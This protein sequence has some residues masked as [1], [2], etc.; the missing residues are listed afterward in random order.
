MVRLGRRVVAKIF[1][2]LGIIPPIRFG[3][4]RRVTPV[5]RSFGLDRGGPI[6]RYYIE[7]F[8]RRHVNDIRGSV[9]EAGGLVNY[10]KEFGGK[11]VSRADVLYPKS[12]FPDGTIVGDL[13]SG[14][15][16]SSDTYD[17]IILTQV[18]PF[19][20]DLH[21]AVRNTFRALRPGGILLA[22]LPG[23][24]Q[25]CRYDMQQWGDYW[26]FTDASARRLFGDVFQTP[27]LTVEAYGNVM[28]ACAFLHGLGRRDLTLEE[29]DYSDPDYQL[30][31]AVRAVKPRS[32]VDVSSG[33][34][35]AP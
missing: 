2:V 8:L 33:T 9:L 14:A 23:I 19:I 6:D 26:R 17:C 30:S 32:N 3:S 10:T 18:Y 5:S 7:G 25:I 24:S 20:Y 35:S 28:V 11:H 4:L 13:E 12:G 15:G 21:A 31:I 29:L 27:D 34:E 22:T 16:I 1:R